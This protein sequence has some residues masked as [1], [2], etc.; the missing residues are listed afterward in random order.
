MQRVEKDEH[1]HEVNLV[2][3][4]MLLLG[5]NL[6]DDLELHESDHEVNDVEKY[7]DSALIAVVENLQEVVYGFDDQDALVNGVRVRVVV[8][9]VLAVMV[10]CLLHIR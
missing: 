8:G 9:A 2:L 7:E 1:H 10:Y 3:L 5:P 4:D 6:V